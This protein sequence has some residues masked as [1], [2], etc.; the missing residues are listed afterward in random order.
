MDPTNVL[1]LGCRFAERGEGEINR[2]FS[3]TTRVVDA[4]SSQQGN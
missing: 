4:A 3:V 2:G 1:N